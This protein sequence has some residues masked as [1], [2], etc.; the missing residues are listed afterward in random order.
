MKLCQKKQ[1]TE[2]QCLVCPLNFNRKC[3]TPCN[4]EF[5]KYCIIQSIQHN[6]RNRNRTVFSLFRTDINIHSI[7]MN[8][9]LLLRDRLKLYL[10]VSIYKA[11]LQV[12]LHT[13]LIQK[14]IVIYLTAVPSVQYGP[15]WMM[16]LNLQ[17]K[18]YLKI[19][20]LI[21]KGELLKVI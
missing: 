4:H 13:I 18:N 6:F 17:Q 9:V 3:T 2:I 20:P 19:C 11:L 12:Q 15:H 1:N 7:K 21:Q 14:E 8:G 5:C 10:V 16:D